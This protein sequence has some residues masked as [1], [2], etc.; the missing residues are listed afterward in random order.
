MRRLL[1]LAVS[2]LFTT[3]GIATAKKTYTFVDESNNPYTPAVTSLP[4]K[5][6]K[7]PSV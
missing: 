6:L 3:A 7:A 5:L 2:L 4:K 1:F